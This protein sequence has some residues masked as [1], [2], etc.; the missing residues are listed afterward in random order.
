MHNKSVKLMYR[1]YF[2]IKKYLCRKLCSALKL[3]MFW[4]MGLKLKMGVE[5][6]ELLYSGWVRESI[7]FIGESF[8]NFDDSFEITLSF[9]IK[10]V[11]IKNRHPYVCSN[12]Y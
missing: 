2:F 7:V 1:C 12:L 4:I 9:H 3:F 5:K 10:G 6:H 8:G 11:T